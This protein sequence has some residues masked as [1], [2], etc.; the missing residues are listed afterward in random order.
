MWQRKDNLREEYRTFYTD[1]IRAR[2]AL[3][4]AG[5]ADDCAAYVDETGKFRFAD[6]RGDEAVGQ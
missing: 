3:R 1:L 2:E 6:E 5:K 4:K